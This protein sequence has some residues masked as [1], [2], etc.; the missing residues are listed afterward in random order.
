MIAFRIAPFVQVPKPRSR[1]GNTHSELGKQ[2]DVKARP[3]LFSVNTDLGAIRE[4]QFLGG[5]GIQD[6]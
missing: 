4:A 5:A 2:S 1:A 3:D 6:E